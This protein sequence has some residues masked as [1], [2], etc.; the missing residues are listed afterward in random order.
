MGMIANSAGAPSQQNGPVSL[1]TY[2]SGQMNQGCRTAGGIVGALLVAF[3]C[4]A[5]KAEGSNLGYGSG[6]SLSDYNGTVHQY[7][8]SGERFRIRGRCQS[9]CTLF[10]AIKNV[11]IERSAALRFHAGSSPISTARMIEA[12]NARLR[13]YLNT[14]NYMNSS[15][16]H[17]ISGSDMISRFG[18]KECPPK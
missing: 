1:Q 15:A 9:A 2:R 16:F 5:A 18:Y 14:G 6:G 4:S 12:Y 7:N 8:A 3:L 11:C 17:T 13:N 10:L